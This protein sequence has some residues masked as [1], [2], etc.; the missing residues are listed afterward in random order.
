MSRPQA[1]RLIDAAGVVKNLSPMG[2]TQPTSKR[3]VRP[4]TRLDLPQQREAWDLARMF[5][6]G[7]LFERLA[8]RRPV[9]P[10]RFLE[11]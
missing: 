4:L 11:Q 9:H 5:P 8:H 1:Y 3:Q 2:D 6:A 7:T 10:R